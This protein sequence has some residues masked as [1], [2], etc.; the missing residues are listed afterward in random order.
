MA[1][2]MENS[3]GCGEVPTTRW[4]PERDGQFQILGVDHKS[5]GL[6]EEP[7]VDMRHRL[8]QSREAGESETNC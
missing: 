4:T 6:E 7:Q 3:M 5:R 1:A 2:N 8:Q